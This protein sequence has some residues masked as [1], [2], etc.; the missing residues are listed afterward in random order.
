M[1]LQAIQILFLKDLFLSRRYLFGYFAGG[2]ASVALAS[3]PNTTAGFVGFIL[4]M[5]VGIAAGIHFIGQ[6]LLAETSDQTRL[7][8]MSM[9]VSLLD[10]SLG[11][12]LVV[13]TTFLIPWGSMLAICTICSFVLPWEKD[14][15]VVIL[16][17]IFL[18]LLCG[19]MIQLATAVITESVG[20]TICIMVGCNIALN[21]F[22]MK[23]L[24][25]PD[26]A[27]VRQSEVVSWPPVILQ[28]I[29]VECLVVLAVFTVA[30]L[31]QC[32]KRDLV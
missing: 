14:G 18:F 17:A 11:K 20:W 2:L 10:Y 21:V 19:F 1:N 23:F 15:S 26:V 25:L 9:P 30:V 24:T 29:T 27:E 13:L 4:I 5:T 6:L 3:V 16:P 8:V 7:F 31:V 32:R 22:L 28:Y 12:I